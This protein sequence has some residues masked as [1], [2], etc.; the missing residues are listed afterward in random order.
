MLLSL[1]LGM[2]IHGSFPVSG[3]PSLTQGSEAPANAGPNPIKVADV[4]AKAILKSVISAYLSCKTYSDEGTVSCPGYWQGKFSTRFKRPYSLCFT[5][6]SSLPK[7][8]KTMYCTTGPRAIRH[9]MYHPPIYRGIWLDTIPTD[10]WDALYE[11]E[12]SEFVATMDRYSGRSGGAGVVIPQL[13]I[14]I[15]SRQRTFNEMSDLVRKSNTDYQHHKCFVLFSPACDTRIWIDKGTLLI[16]RVLV[17]LPGMPITDIHYSPKFNS[18]INDN[19]LTFTPPKE[20][21]RRTFNDAMGFGVFVTRS[22]S[23]S[24]QS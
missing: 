5:Y 8:E 10:R 18:R 12:H 22:T 19:E 16:L 6:E 11:L 15:K 13:L 21:T 7:A 4:K 24:I 14:N 17:H 23:S 20:R 2:F 1:V 3:Q 9:E